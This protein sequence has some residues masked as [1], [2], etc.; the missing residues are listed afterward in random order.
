MTFLDANLLVYL[1]AGVKEV[2]EL[3]KELVGS[4]T[5]CTD[6]LVLDEVI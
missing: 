2:A 5:L 3:F 1:N 6:A 4:Y